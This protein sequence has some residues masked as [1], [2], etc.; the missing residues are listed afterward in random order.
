MSTHDFPPD[1]KIDALIARFPR[2]FHGRQPSVW[3]DLPSGWAELADQLFADLDAMMD[4]DAASRFEVIQIKEK[5]AGLW[6]Y[7]AL[8][9]AETTVIDFIGPDSIQRVDR[10]PAQPTELFNRIQARMTLASEQA[11]TICQHCGNSGASIGGSGW[12]QTLCA[13]CRA[14][15]DAEDSEDP[16]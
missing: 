16:P 9:R 8:D 7:W 3:S 14:I 1:P 11:A 2:L 6:V 15:Q 12:I 13:T 5:F 10:P 4:D